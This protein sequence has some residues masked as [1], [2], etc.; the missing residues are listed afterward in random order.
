M[1]LVA[2][3]KM[4]KY[5]GGSVLHGETAALGVSVLPTGL[6]SAK[7]V[8]TV[9]VNAAVS[10]ISLRVAHVARVTRSCASYR[11]SKPSFHCPT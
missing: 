1:A 8:A 7:L 9:A 11:H 5:R 2:E 10:W 4:M 6:L 3:C